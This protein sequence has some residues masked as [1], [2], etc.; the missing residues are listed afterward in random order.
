M[1]LS[2]QIA[3]HFREIHFGGNWTCSNLKDNMANV[4][5][6]QAITPVQNLKICR[7]LESLTNTP[8]YYYL[9]NYLR[10]KEDDLTS[11]CPGCGNNW[12][13]QSQL[14]ERYDFKCDQCRLVSTLSS[15]S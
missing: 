7:T 8:T 14:H 6:Q 15:C 5:W 12:G 4:T 11:A 2:A 3:K 9:H 1:N 10:Y 13:L